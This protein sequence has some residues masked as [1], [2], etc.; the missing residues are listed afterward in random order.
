MGVPQ[1]KLR[2]GVFLVDPSMDEISTEGTT[3]KIEPRAMRVLVQLAARA[4]EVVSV[5]E[6]L[7]SAW[8]DLIVTPDSVYQAIAALRRAFGDDPKTPRYIIN[9]PRRGYRLVAPVVP[10]QALNTIVQASASAPGTVA[11]TAAASRPSSAGSA[12]SRG[13]WVGSLLVLAALVLGYV[14]L[15][16]RRSSTPVHTTEQRIESVMAPAANSIAVLPFVDMSEKHDHEYF[17]DGLSEE[18]IG[19]LAQSSDLQVTAQTSSFYFKGKQETITDIARTLGVAHIL[20]GSVRVSGNTL[21]ISAQL[22]RGDTGVH[23]WS[24][25]YERELKDVFKL[26][27]EIANAVVSALK[28][29]LGHRAESGATDPSISTEAYDQYLLGVHMAQAGDNDGFRRAAAAL[30][31]A[32]QLDPHFAQA[33]AAWAFNE[34]AVASNTGTSAPLNIA[35]VALDKALSLAPGRADGYAARSWCRADQLDFGGALADAEHAVSLEPRDARF[36]IALAFSLATNGRL[37]EATAIIKKAIALD[38]LNFYAWMT[39]GRLLTVRH[40]WPGARLALQRALEINPLA[41]GA[42]WRLGIVDLLTGHANVAL[43]AFQNL[44]PE[45]LRKSGVAIAQHSAGREQESQTALAELISRAADTSAYLIGMV[46]A[47]RGENDLAFDWLERARRQ[48]DPSLSIIKYDPL[49]AGLVRDPRY[50]TLLHELN[51][52]D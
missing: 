47:W 21:R 25:T 10:W 44:Q 33:Y 34:C 30:E 16:K 29:K 9:V 5:E 13:W 7:A 32:T 40:D 39:L 43:N 3:V 45:D 52:P 1:T 27:D 18:L 12:R 48:R 28:L 38:P 26:Q 2:I 49:L 42:Q 37:T 19:L 51:L 36:Q 6:L 8:C 22:I 35:Q 15:D 4:G 46:C 17:S 20:E 31:R 41:P 50:R 24:G 23:I 11:P 14:L